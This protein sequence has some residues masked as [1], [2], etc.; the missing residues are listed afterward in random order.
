M[1]P[2]GFFQQYYIGVDGR[3]PVMPGQ[4]P[5]P[6]AHD[7]KYGP[8][9]GGQSAGADFAHQHANQGGVPLQY[10]QSVHSTTNGSNALPNSNSLLT[11]GGPQHMIRNGCGITPVTP[12]HK[13]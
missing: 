11:A 5:G 10:Q 1:A 4:V 7:W 8:V 3:R 12:D 2:A 13:M 6:Q 9:W